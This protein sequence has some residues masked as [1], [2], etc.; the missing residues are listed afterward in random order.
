MIAVVILQRRSG[1]GLTFFPIN[2]TVLIFLVKKRYDEAFRDVYFLRIRAKNFKSNLVLVVVLVFESTGV[3]SIQQKFRS[4]IS[5]IPRTQWN[6]T[7]RLYRPNP[8]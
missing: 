3:H 4:K 7:F 8:S 2:I 5:E 1:K 6:G